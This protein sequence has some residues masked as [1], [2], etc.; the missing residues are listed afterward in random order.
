MPDTKS[1][2]WLP[3]VA[4]KAG[5]RGSGIAQPHDCPLHVKVPCGIVRLLRV[6][7]R[8]HVEIDAPVCCFFLCL[9][10]G[11]VFCQRGYHLPQL[12]KNVLSM[13]LIVLG[14]CTNR[15]GLH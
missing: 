9:G 11:N 10:S 8:V 15:R 6:L 7:Q 5:A 1:L 4:E 12:R 3:R 2:G 13:G 14:R